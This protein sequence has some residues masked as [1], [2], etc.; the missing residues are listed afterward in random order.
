MNQLI[1]EKNEYD[2]KNSNDN[3][4]NDD[5]DEY[6]DEPYIINF[7]IENNTVVE[8]DSKKPHAN[9]WI[10]SRLASALDSAK[11]SDR[12]ALHILMATVEALGHNPDELAISRSTIHRSRQENR[13]NVKTDDMFEERSKYLKIFQYLIMYL[14][15]P[16][17]K[18]CN[19]IRLKTQKDWLFTGMV[20]CS[21]IL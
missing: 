19:L 5:A 20:K 4:N 9:R 14:S 11:L 12:K 13:Q 16:L 10:T 7:D 2:D 15:T 1:G 6:L 3:K 17:R 18:Y 8:K 21:R